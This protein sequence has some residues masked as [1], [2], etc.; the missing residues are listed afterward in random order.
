MKN[1]IQFLKVV[2]DIYAIPLSD[3][4]YYVFDNRESSETVKNAFPDCKPNIIYSVEQQVKGNDFSYKGLTLDLKVNGRKYD[5]PFF[6]LYNKDGKYTYGKAADSHI[7]V[8]IMAKD[9]MIYS[10][11]ASLIEMIVNGNIKDLPLPQ[12]FY[13][14]SKYFCQF[15][16]MDSLKVKGKTG[17]AINADILQSCIRRY[18]SYYCDNSN[19]R[20][21]LMQCKPYKDSKNKY[22]ETEKGD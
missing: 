10:F 1:E 17:F 9:S 15:N 4:N 7:I 21:L 2:P 11:P 5:R 19:M 18:L 12:D 22:T 8:S 14:T 16:D 20:Y 3:F 6:E 13:H